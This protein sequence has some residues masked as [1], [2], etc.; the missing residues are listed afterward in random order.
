MKKYISLILLFNILFISSGYHLY[1]K[2]LQYNIQQDI[3]HEIR[4][5]ISEKKLTLIVVSSNN[6]KVIKW[7]KKNKEFEYKGLMYD[8]VKTKIKNNYYYYYCINDVEEKNLIT[9]YTIQ[10]RCKNKILLKLKKNLS[11]KYFPEKFS[12]NTETIKADIYFPE[13]HKLYN[14]TYLETLSPP[15]KI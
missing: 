9:N 10:N 2:Y 4:K 15:P 14:S 1:F 7:T 3:Q 12:I 11:N 13:Y 5:G 6:E 8:V